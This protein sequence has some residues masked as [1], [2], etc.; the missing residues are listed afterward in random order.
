[1][2]RDERNLVETAVEGDWHMFDKN[3]LSASVHL[4]QRFAQHQAVIRRL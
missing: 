2:H 4:V 3:L 1:M